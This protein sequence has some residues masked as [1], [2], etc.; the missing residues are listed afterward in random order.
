MNGYEVVKFIYQSLEIDVEL[1]SN[2]DTVWLTKEQ[3]SLLFD[4]DRS[5]IT[6]H[7]H[8]IYKG[9]E[10]DKNSTCAKN[11]HVRLEGSRRVVG[12]L[13]TINWTLF[14]WSVTAL[15]QIRA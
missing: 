1:S 5:V 8:N 7:I 2:R 10:L 12:L 14:F 13:S 3:M 9:G 11:A 6:K 4:R 15:I